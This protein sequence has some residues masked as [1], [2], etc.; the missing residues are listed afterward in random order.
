MRLMIPQFRAFRNPMPGLFMTQ[1]R[2]AY[3]VCIHAGGS[4]IIPLGLFR[5]GIAYEIATRV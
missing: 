2:T 3:G 5:H 1:A 4:A